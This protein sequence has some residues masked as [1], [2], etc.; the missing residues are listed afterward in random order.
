[1]T[2]ILSNDVDVAIPYVA[3][4]NFSK[5]EP[6]V[7]EF[8]KNVGSEECRSKVFEFQ[9]LVLKNKEKLLPMFEEYAK[10]K[11][12]TFKMGYEAAFEYCVLEF[13]FAFWQW[14][15]LACEE[16]PSNADDINAVF[17]AFEKVGFS[18]SLKKEPNQFARS[19]TRL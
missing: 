15:D 16:I 12:M 14:G 13:S 4:I 1:M 18:F 17:S 5:E 19:F 9:K 6:R 3:P 7:F 11:E 8:L 2:N 10:E